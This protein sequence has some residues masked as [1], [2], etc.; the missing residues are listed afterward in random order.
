[1]QLFLVTAIT[2]QALYLARRPL[3]ES[4]L[5]GL[6]ERELADV[7]GADEV[8][9]GPIGGSWLF[10]VRVTGI[11]I[12]GPRALVEIEDGELDVSVSPWRLA[13][14]N[15]DGLRAAA[16]QA[17][18][19]GLRLT[20]TATAEDDDVATATVDVAAIREIVS[21]VGSG[22][23]TVDVGD[24]ALQI[25]DLHR[26]GP[27]RVRLQPGHGER[28]LELRYGSDHVRATAHPRDGL[29]VR[30]SL[31]EP[32]MLAR[33]LGIVDLPLHGGVFSFGAQL[34][35][36]PLRLHVRAGLLD[37]S[38]DQAALPPCSAELACDAHGLEVLQADVRL[39]GAALRAHRLML[40]SPLPNGDGVR[41][42][43]RRLRGDLALVFDD[44]APTG[45]H[46]PADLAPHLP[47]RGSL[48]AWAE[49]GI[50]HLRRSE[51]SGR[52]AR[53]TVTSGALPIE[54]DVRRLQGNVSMLL[55][56]TTAVDF[57]PVTLA[58][59][60]EG[61]IEG[62]LSDPLLD[63][64]VDTSSVRWDTLAADRIAGRVRFAGGSFVVRDLVCR[65]VRDAGSDAGAGD[66]DGS[67]TFELPDGDRPL[68]IDAAV[69]GNVSPIW[70]GRLP[71][72]IP[73]ELRPTQASPFDLRG[74]LQLS[75]RP[76]GA[77]VLALHDVRLSGLP[78]LALSADVAIDEAA[79]DVK[80]LHVDGGSALDANGR[81]PWDETAPLTMSVRTANLRLDL[82]PLG[83]SSLTGTVAARIDVA[84][85]RRAPTA[86]LHLL[87]G[88]DDL[89]ARHPDWWPL[90][91]PPPGTANVELA[92]RLDDTGTHVERL[93]ID[94]G[95]DDR[96][97][98]LGMSGSLPVHLTSDG[99]RSVVGDGNPLPPLR[100]HLLLRAT[101]P[102]K[103]ASPLSGSLD[104][105]LEP[106]RLSFDPLRIGGHAGSARGTAAIGAG[107]RQI[108]DPAAWASAPLT[109]SV[110]LDT[111]D[112]ETWLPPATTGLPVVAGRVDARIEVGGEL[113][114][115]QPQ[116]D[117][118]LT[119]GA[120]KLP[121]LQRIEAISARA[122]VTAES[123]ELTALDATMGA[124]EVHGS[125]SL[126]A[127]AGK[128]LW[129]DPAATVDL[130]LNGKDLLVVRGAGFKMRGNPELALT[131]TL[132]DL[133]LKGRFAVTAGKYVRRQTLLPDLRIRGGA[134]ATDDFVPFHIP[135]P[136][137]ERLRFDV[138]VET[139]APFNVLTHVFDCDLSGSAHLRGP[140]INPYFVGSVSGGA[141]WLRFPGATLTVDSV[142]VSGSEK[143][144]QN[145]DVRMSATGQRHGVRITMSVNGRYPDFDVD[146]SSVPSMP[147]QDLL[148]LLTAGVLPDRLR[149]ATPQERAQMLS[150]YL[151]TELFALYYGSESTEREEGFA[152]RFDIQYGRE[153][154]KNGLESIVIEFKL[155][156]YLA[157]R[158][159]RDVY[160]DY[161]MGIVL[162]FR[163]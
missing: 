122:V 108:L 115:P 82:L 26:S 158:A 15:L 35:V 38:W 68:V 131:G 28:E 135:P 3:F 109:G 57:G 41:F 40:P 111:I 129:D 14:G 21:T 155:G 50:V 51:I 139:I 65:G 81:I 143:H 33:H 126:R 64:I 163:F 19:A 75:P 10:G 102:R 154:S 136:L 84:G 2:A 151:A 93:T 42:D 79:L 29:A 18:S 128:L 89:F 141:G 78:P 149:E 140:G 94:V 27:L 146:L 96:L 7:L 124:G 16:L 103:P 32:G 83:D 45:D 114:R 11:G 44:F 97:V 110:T 106:D 70:L 74:R 9:L 137:G 69:R 12:R 66:L 49:N 160:E 153:I 17:R 107:A 6:L 71:L 31:A 4:T 159:E 43:P 61:Q 63:V 130:S 52:L 47:L 30:G 24:F 56:A 118:Q 91:D 36:E 105:E 20:T 152:N 85:T 37:A 77:A 117:L 113:R 99:L 86:A 23:A 39:P 157:L 112:L 116:I 161:N 54:T 104:F 98:A 22:G 120:V 134:S 92:V 138:A 67:V 133:L 144:P 127:S 150:S 162:R 59:R 48:F 148:V 55:E 101:D 13:S 147:R 142:L 72:A 60:V 123:I 90:A 46:V 5:R 58:G 8:R 100:G 80:S 76:I 145:P 87:G 132:R 62:T 125:G 121:G 95:S 119:G 34:A 73:A 53:L 1:M 88:V 156:D 25:G